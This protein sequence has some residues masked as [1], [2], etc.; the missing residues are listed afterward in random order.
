MAGTATL[1]VQGTLTGG[2]TGSENFATGSIVNTSAVEYVQPVALANGF[3]SITV[4][5]GAKG[6]YI[7]MA[8]G[9][10]SVTTIKGVTGDTGLPIAPAG[11]F[12]MSFASSPPATIGITITTGTTTCNII[13]I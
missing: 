13:W 9:N 6:M 2:V 3:N 1:T 8:A 7:I 10:T 11:I 12:V 5:T 4:P